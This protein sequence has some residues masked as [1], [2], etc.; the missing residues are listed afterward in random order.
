MPGARYYANSW[1]D[2]NG[3]LWLF[4]GVGDASGGDVGTL[5]DLWMYNPG[6]GL[7]TWESGSNTVGA[8]GTYGNGVSNGDP[9]RREGAAGWR[10]GAGNCGC[11]GAPA[12]MPATTP[13]FSMICGSIEDRKVACV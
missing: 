11:S 2:K 8:V 12:R 9:G 7:W 1:T 3:N 13:D 10:D 6:T 5:S 4:G